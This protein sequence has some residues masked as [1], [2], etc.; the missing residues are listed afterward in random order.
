MT[1]VLTEAEAA[2]ILKISYETLKKARAKGA[3]PTYRQVGRLIRYTYQDI[4]EYLDA[5]K[6][7][8]ISE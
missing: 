1:T 4:E 8:K 7:K 6:V 2:S 5:N 3:G